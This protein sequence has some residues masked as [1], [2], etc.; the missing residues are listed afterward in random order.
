MK[1]VAQAILLAF[2]GFS[3]GALMAYGPPPPPPG[4]LYYCE[5]G[6]LNAVG[7]H[8]GATLVHQRAP[9]CSGCL[10]PGGFVPANLPVTATT[11]LLH[12]KV[13]LPATAMPLR[14]RVV[15]VQGQGGNCGYYDA[16][17]CWCDTWPNVYAVPTSV[18]GAT[19]Y[20]LF[21]ASD[22]QDC[23]YGELPTS[24]LTAEQLAKKGTVVAVGAQSW[25]HPVPF[26][27]KDGQSPV[28]VGVSI[29]PLELRPRV[30]EPYSVRLR[31][32]DPRDDTHQRWFFCSGRTASVSWDGKLYQYTQ[33][34]SATPPQGPS[35]YCQSSDYFMEVKV[36]LSDY[37][38][39]PD[40]ASMVNLDCEMEFREKRLA[41]AGTLHNG[42]CITREQTL[43]V[44]ICPTF[45]AIT[46]DGGNTDTASW[47][48]GDAPPASATG[49]GPV[50]EPRLW[51]TVTGGGYKS[52]VASLPGYSS[53][54]FP[55]ELRAPVIDCQIYAQDPLRMNPPCRVLATMVFWLK[56]ST[57]ENCSGCIQSR[58]LVK[59]DRYKLYDNGSTVCITHNDKWY[60]DNGCDYYG[61]G[62]EIWHVPSNA[63]NFSLPTQSPPNNPL[64]DTPG[65]GLTDQMCA[66]G[67]DDDFEMYIFYKADKGCFAV[68]MLRVPWSCT[69]YFQQDLGA[70]GCDT[71]EEFYSA[72]NVDT[73]T[74]YPTLELWDC[75][76]YDE[77]D[78]TEDSCQ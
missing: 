57:A 18:P 2:A 27:V 36:L 40:F 16:G 19:D 4:D 43:P 66:A 63:S 26:P 1:S 33:G 49:T 23:D 8:N 45:A 74:V 9:W 41:I 12:T 38:A 7:S 71:W 11:G 47:S 29:E 48:G 14:E 70:T 22:I 24:A 50:F 51:R 5:R 67:A 60:L 58:Q 10:D 52:I 28:T 61:A 30:G 62:C 42:E 46:S 17:C 54:F 37:V 78:N 53:A 35:Y 68:P 65:T 59:S 25:V 64:N 72:T 44:G 15:A 21:N 77:H 34:P 31:I 13:G 73:E 76:N 69:Y 6:T 20:Y 3:S 75:S 39:G 32:W 55:I 56:V